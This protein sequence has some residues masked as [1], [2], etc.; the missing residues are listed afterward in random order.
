MTIDKTTQSA[1]AALWDAGYKNTAIARRLRM[2]ADTVYAAV[3]LYR[4]QA[5]EKWISE[6]RP[7]R[8]RLDRPALF[9]GLSQRA[10]GVLVRAGCLNAT[11]KAEIRKAWPD[12][13]KFRN[14]RHCGAKTAGEIINW[15]GD[16][17]T[18]SC[19][20]CEA[21][22]G[23]VRHTYGCPAGEYWVGGDKPK[24]N[25]PRFI[26]TCGLHTILAELDGRNINAVPLGTP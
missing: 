4:E 11:T 16:A 1:V 14:V 24:R 10:Y 3:E 21:L 23:Y 5:V 12:P 26:C 19:K 18:D 15:L 2:P 22:R 25:D 20:L 13:T 9:D 6:G 7:E 17:M 8:E